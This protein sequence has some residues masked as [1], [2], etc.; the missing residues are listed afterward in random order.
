MV[1]LKSFRRL[2][3]VGLVS[4]MVWAHMA[5]AAHDPRINGFATLGVAVGDSKRAYLGAI[6]DTPNLHHDTK[7]G[8]NISSELSDVWSFGSQFVSSGARDDLGLSADWLFVKY[9][10]QNHFS[11]RFGR[12]KLGNRLLSE[13]LDVGFAYPWVRPPQEVYSPINVKTIEGLSVAYTLPWGAWDLVME[14]F[15]AVADTTIFTYSELKVQRKTRVMADHVRGGVVTLNHDFGKL[16]VSHLSADV[17]VN[18]SVIIKDRPVSL[19]S[20]A[21]QMDY[22]DVVVYGEFARCGESNKKAVDDLQSEVAQLTTQQTV[23]TDAV[24]LADLQSK[25]QFS[26]FRLG[27]E[28]QSLLVDRAYYLTLG[29]RFGAILPHFTYAKLQVAERA[30]LRGQS[31][32]LLGVRNNINDKLAMKFDIQQISPTGNKEGLYQFSNPVTQDKGHVFSLSI[33]TIF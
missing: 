25:L 18:G 3:L 30:V 22:R 19:W 20:A 29:Y 27:S 6:D 10:P 15:V 32:L 21:T 11:V 14:P 2:M 26:Q 28:Q 5:Q 1:E 16:M 17:S 24:V 9:Q 31:S 7:M 12:Q 13:I 23:A 4:L 8:L 33:D